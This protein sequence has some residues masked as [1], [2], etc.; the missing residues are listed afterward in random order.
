MY[1]QKVKSIK[2]WK[3]PIFV[4]ILKATD[5][6]I[7]IRGS[8]TRWYGSEDQDPYQN[9]TDSQH[10]FNLKIFLFYGCKMSG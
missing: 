8:V 10:C 1:I 9:V 4:D 5:E 2:T 3:I 6:K 7:R